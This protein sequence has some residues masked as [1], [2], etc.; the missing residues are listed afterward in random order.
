MQRRRTVRRWTQTEEDRLIRQVK[1]FPQNLHKCFLIVA[2]ETGRTPGA[3]AN[4]WYTK[5]SKKPENICMLQITSHSALYNRKNGAGEQ[6]PSRLW[7]RI[8]NAVRSI[9]PSWKSA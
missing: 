9:F 6:T 1:V 7:T 2:E 5:T 4:H 3:V 8:M